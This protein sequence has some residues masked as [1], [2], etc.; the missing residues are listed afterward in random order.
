M[1]FG[2]EFLVVMVA[3]WMLAGTMFTASW[4]SLDPWSPKNRVALLTRFQALMGMG[5]VALG[6]IYYMDAARTFLVVLGAVAMAASLG[7]RFVHG[8][9]VEDEIDFLHEMHREMEKGMDAEMGMGVDA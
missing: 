1:M 3:S 6:A 7:L 4:A 9:V 8:K 2:V 5:T